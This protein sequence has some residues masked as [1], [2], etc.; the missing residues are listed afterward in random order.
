MLIKWRPHA[1]SYYS[2]HSL[3]MAGCVSA[4]NYKKFYKPLA[5]PK[6]LQDVNC[7]KQVKNRNYFAQPA[8]IAT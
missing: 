5:D 8:L 4:N 6:A 3:I 7:C 1:N 2:S